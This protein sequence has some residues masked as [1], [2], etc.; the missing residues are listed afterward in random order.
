MK[1]NKK[2]LSLM[3]HGFDAKLLSS[4]NE[5]QI[6]SMYNRLVESKKVP[7]KNKKK[8]SKEAWTEKPIPPS[9]EMTGTLSD[10]EKGVQVNGFVQ[11][12]G[13]QVIVKQGM[14]ENELQEDDAGDLDLALAMQSKEISEKFESKAQQKYFWARCNDDS[15]SAKKKKEWCSMAKEFSEKTKNIKKLPKKKKKETKEGYSDWV[16]GA[17]GKGLSRN[18]MDNV[19]PSFGESEKKLNNIVEKY[20]T[21]QMTKKDFLK[22][23]FETDKKEKEKE[24]TKEKEKEREKK[25]KPFDP[26]D[27]EPDKKG[28]PKAKKRETNEDSMSTLTKPVT[29]PKPDTKPIT[30]PDTKPKPFDP[31]QPDPDKKGAPKARRGSIPSWLSSHSI[32]I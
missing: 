12:Q 10:L 22:L 4:L 14:E 5:N 30:K 23:V 3:N 17:Y 9:K 21:P 32:G 25:P 28:A 20:L 26:F 19:N 6:N 29:K 18:A 11:K 31:F 1:T 27:P 8:E 2:I 13:N 15:L 24:R 7:V 16:M